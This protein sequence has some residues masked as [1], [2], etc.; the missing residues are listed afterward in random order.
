MS[1][2]DEHIARVEKYGYNRDNFPCTY[3]G[4]ELHI[5]SND[6]YI[7]TDER[8]LFDFTLYCRK[9]ERERGLS[10]RLSNNCQDRMAAVVGAKVVCFDT[11]KFEECE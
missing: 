1:Q 7:D 9:C 11:F 8:L 10:G 6:A 2:L 5:L 3:K 4:H